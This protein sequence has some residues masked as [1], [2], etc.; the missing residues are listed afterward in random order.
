MG[1]IKGDTRSVDYDS[2]YSYTLKS[3]SLESI[4]RLYTAIYI[5]GVYIVAID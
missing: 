1:D 3:T 5:L 2:Y 4:L